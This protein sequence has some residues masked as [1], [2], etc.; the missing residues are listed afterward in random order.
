MKN[1]LKSTVFAL[2]LLAAAAVATT[3]C[4]DSLY[5]TQQFQGG[6]CVNVFGPC[7]VAR[8]GELRFIGS[9]LDQI[10]AVEIPGCASITDIQRVSSEEI[11]VTVPQ[12]AMEGKVV[13][14]YSGGTITTKTPIR[15][16]EPVSV[17][18]LT[19]ASIK[20]GDILEIKGEYLNLMSEVCFSFLEGRD[21][22]NVFADDF[23]AHERNVI[24]VVVP[25]EAVSG[26]VTVSDA[27]EIPQMIKS[28]K[29]I[30]VVLPAVEKP[31][32]L[33]NAVPGSTV[34]VK[35]TDFDLVR[36][37]VMPNGSEV[38]FAY[39]ADNSAISF[40]LPANVIDGAI[41][42]M[43]ASGVKVAIAN[44]GVVVPT[45]LTATPSDGI[46]PGDEIAVKGVNMDQVA[47]VTIPNAG[48]V[49]LTYTS[50]TEIRFAYPAMGQSGD[51]VLNLFSGKQATVALTTAKPEVQAFEPATVSAA[52]EFKMVGRNLDLVSQVTFNG[53]I[54][55]DVTPS[56]A[57]ELTMT[58]D[59][60]AQS[61][62]LTLTMANGETVTTP[63]LTIQAP[64]CCF[65]TNVL[66]ENLIA[67]ELMEAEVVNGDKLTNV[68]VN[69]KACQFIINGSRLLI[70]LPADCGGKS[71]V[72]LVSSNGSIDYQ[73]EIIGSTHQSI[74][75][76]DEPVDF[77][78]WN[79]NVVR[80]YKEQLEGVPAGAQM[81]FHLAAYDYTQ[82][83]VNNANWSQYTI[84]ESADIVETLTFDLTADV[85]NDALNTSDGWSTTAFIM[86]G[87]GTVV[88]KVTIEYDLK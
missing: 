40:V 10:N 63:A 80:V 44:I 46:R 88:N 52:A 60:N 66:T 17:D 58:A 78:N 43:P 9:G 33:T 12:T 84:L 85:L 73:Y 56:S 64:E 65:I 34:T 61:G 8:G 67:G 6:V 49:A 26:I 20:P 74:V 28:K 39:D 38:D 75:V 51:A 53:G 81:V 14:R 5:D 48:E 76:W 50:A 22:V 16:S 11:R 42:A 36:S 2:S 4:S 54:T 71:T 37:V 55:V 30:A 62:A 19:P 82:I 59:P 69:A 87:K 21:S 18:E 79:G 41:V 45:E 13:L 35:G 70:N 83:Q 23:I 86:Q 27:A 1:I 68:L 15:Y 47:S 7:P 57:T 29:E 24:K 3:S 77:G 31:V 32:D 25:E 72:T